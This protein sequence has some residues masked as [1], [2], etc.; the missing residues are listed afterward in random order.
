ME[1][2]F[3]LDGHNDL[4]WE[5]R[6]RAGPDL[7]GVDLLAGCPQVQTDL[8]RLRAG[9]VGAQFWSVFVPAELAGDAAVTA[10]FEQ[11][12]LVRRM[13]ERYPEHLALATTAAEVEQVVAS[14]RIASLLGVEGG[15]SINSSLGVLRCLHALGARYLTLT[16]NV[17]VPW[18]D[19]ATDVPT[20]GGL[21][22]L[23]VGVVAESNRLGMFVDL[24]HVADTVM[25]RALDVSGAPVL[26]SHSGARAVCDI[27]RNVPDDVLE[28]LPANGGVCMVA[29][30]AMFVKQSIADWYLE[31]VRIVAERGGDPRTYEDVMAVV[32]ERSALAPIPACTAEDVADHLDHI[33]DVA[34]VAHV[35]IG[36]DFDGA[37]SFPIDLADVGGYPRLFEVLRE[38]RWSRADLAAVAHGNVLRAMR[39]MEDAAAG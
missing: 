11:V 24:S 36:S 5:L 17:N 19:S 25:H 38:R 39:H 12:D 31:T 35:G 8:P 23:G 3:V 34:G 28:R 27:V 37:P 9:G 29:F 22:D 14:G 15:H 18:A 26:F 20:V 32:S 2:P 1:I 21:T 13:V 6:E 16:H 33:R 4:P 30:A 7:A 10:T